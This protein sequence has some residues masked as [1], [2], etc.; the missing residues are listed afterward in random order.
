MFASVCFIQQWPYSYYKIWISIFYITF[1]SKF[2][3]SWHFNNLLNVLI[4]K[5]FHILF[6][7]YK[8]SNSNSMDSVGWM[9][10]VLVYRRVGLLPFRTSQQW[11]ILTA[12]VRLKRILANLRFPME[13]SLPTFSGQAQNFW[14]SILRRESLCLQFTVEFDSGR[15]SVITVTYIGHMYLSFWLHSKMNFSN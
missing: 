1:V 9:L 3:V 13:S 11:T 6:N 14:S 12:V 4:E 7:T 8:M 2:N 15:S 5:M 10:M